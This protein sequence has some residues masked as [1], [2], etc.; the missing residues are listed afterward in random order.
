M[1]T[2]PDAPPDDLAEEE[3]ELDELTDDLSER[4][5]DAD[6]ADLLDQARAVP[7][8]DDDRDA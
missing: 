6:E 7:P 8:E 4:T 2:D 1:P 3:A 5:R